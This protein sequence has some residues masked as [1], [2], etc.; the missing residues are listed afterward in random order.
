MFEKKISI[1]ISNFS[2]S[3]FNHPVLMSSNVS[4]F[5]STVIFRTPF[6]LL[7]LHFRRHAIVFL[8]VALRDLKTLA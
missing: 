3:Y 5:S 6:G 7:V 4:I 2:N 8:I 1:R